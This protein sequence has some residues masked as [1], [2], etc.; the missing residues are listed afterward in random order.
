VKTATIKK[1]LK[2]LPAKER[3]TLLDE[4]R[5]LPKP[6]G[7]PQDAIHPLEQFI[8][9]LEASQNLSEKQLKDELDIPKW[10]KTEYLE[11]LA[12]LLLPIITL[13]KPAV[14]LEMQ[15]ELAMALFM[16]SEAE[17][18]ADVIKETLPAAA[19][20]EEFGMVLRLRQLE[21][22]LELKAR[23]EG[24]TASEATRRKKNLDAFEYL[25]QDLRDA[26]EE[27][28]LQQR[29]QA[30]QWIRTNP[31]LSTDSNPESEKA[32]YWY[33]K[34]KA[35]CALHLR[36]YDEAVEA[37]NRLVGSIIDHPWLGMNQQ[38]AFALELKNF[39]HTLYRWGGEEFSKSFAQ[40]LLDTEFSTRRAEQEK[41]FL[42]FP[43]SIHIARKAGDKEG[44]EQACVFFLNIVD[45]KD[46][47]LANT[48]ITETLYHCAYLYLATNNL[49]G[50]AMIFRRITQNQYGK[51]DFKPQVYTMHRFLEIIYEIE[52]EDWE[53]ATRRIKNLGMSA[54]LDQLPGIKQALSCLNHA[55]DR[56]SI[57]TPPSTPLK[58]DILQKTHQALQGQDFLEYFDLFTWLDAKQKNC[59]MIEIYYDQAKSDA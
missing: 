19:G 11:T 39:A 36:D 43:S 27:P 16:E 56:W 57:D 9:Y 47:P 18:A 35:D 10:Q 7:S 37:L 45:G 26:M 53:D 6:K 44:G 51:P 15:Y 49:E 31:L 32:R 5:R 25:A 42:L 34:I 58:P 23:L 40:N 28:D 8:T 52:R 4:I 20:L 48:F 12:D 55:I 13:R 38:Y 14:Q 46:F 33:W 59:P 41:I 54:G 29:N 24:M 2:T 22:A 30:L 21:E 3:K 17:A 1:I 50:V